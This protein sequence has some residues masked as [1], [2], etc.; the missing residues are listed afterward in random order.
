[1]TLNGLAGRI[2][3]EAKTIVAM[4]PSIAVPLAR[5]RGAGHGQ[6]FDRDTEI[7]I[8]G[9]PRSGNVF[10]IAAFRHAQERE[11]RIANRVHAPGHV[12]AALDAEL[13]VMVLIREPEES[14]LG[15]VVYRGDISVG[16]ALRAYR[17]FYAPLLPHR[18]RFVVARFEDVTSDFGAVIRR[19]NQRFATD[20]AEFDHTEENVQR[21]FRAMESY[22]TAHRGPEEAERFL[23]RPS[24]A[25][26]QMKESMR[27][28]YRSPRLARSRQKAERL[29]GIFSS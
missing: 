25:R 5:R 21:L 12:I 10:A 20:F 17:R 14:V 28:S 22:V 9:F 11:I 15:W 16:Q 18:D 13:P 4:Y 26:E 27:A 19:V 24:A 1:M 29:Y 7:V 3:Y 8:E 2:I 6:V 23:A